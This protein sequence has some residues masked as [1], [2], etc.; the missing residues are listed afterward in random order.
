MGWWTSGATVHGG[1]W[2]GERLEFTRV[3]ARRCCGAQLLAAMAR[4]A[5][6]RCEEPSNGLTWDGEVVRRASG[7]GERNPAVVVGVKALE[8][9]RWANETG[10]RCR[11]TKVGCGAV[12]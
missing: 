1:P 12:L 9:R 2:T 4:G 8:E 10:K 5:R 7:G 11:R 6:G 3:Q